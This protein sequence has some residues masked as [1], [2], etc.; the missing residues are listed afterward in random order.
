MARTRDTAEEITGQS[1]TIEIEL[2]KVLAGVEACRTLGMPSNVGPGVGQRHDG[3]EQCWPALFSTSRLVFFV[4]SSRVVIVIGYV[5]VDSP[6]INRSKENYR[7][8]RTGS[9]STREFK[10]EAHDF[11]KPSV[12]FGSKAVIASVTGTETDPQGYSRQVKTRR[13][14]GVLVAAARL[15]A[16]AVGAPPAFSLRRPRLSR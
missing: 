13:T 10:V 4:N 1:R 3:S 2:G 7:I 5:Y 14:A 11:N 8:V 16:Q 6:H 15:A 9:N 12:R